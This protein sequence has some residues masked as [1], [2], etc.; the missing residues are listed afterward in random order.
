[1]SSSEKLQPASA[2]PAGLAKN[3]SPLALA[4]ETIQELT[5]TE[6]AAVWG[7]NSQH[8]KEIDLPPD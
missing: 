2:S 8:Q 5:S 7:G 6:L 3:E 4:R 1:M